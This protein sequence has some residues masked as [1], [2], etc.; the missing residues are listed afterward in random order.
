MIEDFPA[1]L[2]PINIVI[3]L[4]RSFIFELIARKFSSS[5]EFSIES[6]SRTT[7]FACQ[8]S[9]FG[10]ATLGL[11]ACQPYFSMNRNGCLIGFLANLFGGSRRASPRVALPKVMVNKKFVSAAEGDCFRV[12]RAV[13]GARA[14]L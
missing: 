2:R 11:R 12:L 9:K 5:I 4:T 8:V 7:P 14:Q 1:L 6:H 10:Y 3:G 13:V